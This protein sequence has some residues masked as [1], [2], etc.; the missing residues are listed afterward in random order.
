MSVQALRLRVAA[1]CIDLLLAQASMSKEQTIM[2]AI[3]TRC[4]RARSVIAAILL[5]GTAAS[6][7]A[8]SIVATGLP[9]GESSFIPTGV[10]GDGQTV[11]GNSARRA[12][13][14][15]AAEGFL[16]LG[17]PAGMTDVI[18]SGIS[19]DGQVVS[20]RLFGAGGFRAFR[21]TPAGGFQ[22]LGLLPGGSF[23]YGEA[24]SRNGAAIVGQANNGTNRY[25]AIRWTNALG[26][27]QLPHMAESISDATAWG[28]NID[29][30]VLVGQEFV[31]G[32][33]S[34]YRGFRWTAAGGTV[35]LGTLA[36]YR[37]SKAFR[38]SADGSVIA[39]VSYSSGTSI[40]PV[41]WVSG[42][43][44]NLGLPGSFTEGTPFAMSA[45]GSVIGLQLR[46]DPRAGMWTA[47]TGTVDLNTYL[48]TRGIDMTGWVLTRTYGVSADGLTLVGEAGRID[49]MGIF[50]PTAFVVHLACLVAPTVLTQPEPAD[51]CPT[52][53]AIFSAMATGNT[54]YLWQ[55]QPAG[56]GTAWEALS[57]G[58]NTNS[59][60]TPAFE[61][62][63]ASMSFVAVQ[64]ISGQGG[65]F[66]CLLTNDC[67]SVASDEATLTVL[68]PSSPACSPCNYDFNRDQNI[69][70][71]DAQQMAQV[72]VGLI[73]LQA[74]WLDG[75]L[76][77]DENADL[78]D[79]QLL[80]AFVVTGICGV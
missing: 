25:S 20:G 30:S 7:L 66:R 58:I 19:D 14:W 35:N 62:A 22:N 54:T 75:D 36:G 50:R 77:G 15:T 56:P 73:T 2:N 41:R 26:M 63:G 1:C 78:T 59:Q 3:A 13:I 69:D 57:D 40:F 76:N 4:L 53:T 12:Y 16:D 33:S 24:I 8:Q 72:F 45:D 49:E 43:I 38:V 60:G 46:M 52:G 9:P 17:M 11:I 71:L 44:T 74:E 70:L 64:S 32:T 31:G 29:G 37:N 47:A 18:S 28:T 10:S 27:T 42:V 5:A 51:V 6:S 39:G 68:P 67:G 21:W 55:W 48:P 80:A 34:G 61:V 79:A 23:S 65:N